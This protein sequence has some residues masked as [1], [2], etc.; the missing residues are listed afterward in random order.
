MKSAKKLARTLGTTHKAQ[1]R[2]SA[3]K[4]PLQPQGF[5]LL[6]ARPQHTWANF[7][8]QNKGFFWSAVHCS[9]DQRLPRGWA[10]GIGRR[11]RVACCHFYSETKSPTNL[12]FKGGETLFSLVVFF[13]KKSRAGPRA[14]PGVLRGGDR[15]TPGAARG[16]PGN[17]WSAKQRPTKKTPCFDDGSSS[18]CVGAAPAKVRNPAVAGDF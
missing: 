3:L 17:L 8:H 10:A 14:A 5:A 1:P 2:R 16:P 11:P 18:R 4:N 9:A 12:L 7:R 15:G 13:K 6:R